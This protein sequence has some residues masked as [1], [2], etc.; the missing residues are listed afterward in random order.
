M[1]SAPRCE[2]LRT[3]AA[4]RRDPAEERRRAQLRAKIAEG[5]RRA[6]Q[7]ER[8][9][10]LVDGRAIPRPKNLLR[11]AGVRYMERSSAS[12]SL[13]EVQGSVLDPRQPEAASTTVDVAVAFA[14]TELTRARRR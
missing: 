4:S 5:R 1:K 11:D 2:S 9:H 7:A 8:I 6:C 3:K 12:S 14:V 10:E 13:L